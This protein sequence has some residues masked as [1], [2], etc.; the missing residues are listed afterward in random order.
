SSAAGGGVRRAPR[1]TAWLGAACPAAGLLG[2]RGVR[3]PRLPTWPGAVCRA[4][5]LLGL[6][7]L[8]GARRPCLAARPGAGRRGAPPRG[9]AGAGPRGGGE[10]GAAPPPVR[11]EFGR[12]QPARPSWSRSRAP[13]KLASQL[14]A[15]AAHRAGV[16]RRVLVPGRAVWPA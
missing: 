6:L 12:R 1:L 5:G 11:R 13:A 15:R 9:V 14:R 3:G 16:A 7:G 2:L 8:P 4:I 10:G